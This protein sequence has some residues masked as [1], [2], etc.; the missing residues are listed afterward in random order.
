MFKMS[1]SCGD[2]CHSVGITPVDTLLIPYRASGLD[3]GCNAGLPCYFDTV[4]EGEGIRSHYRTVEVES[5]APALAMACLSASLGGLSDTAGQKHGIFGEYYGVGLECLTS[6]LAKADP[7]LRSRGDN[8][9]G[10]FFRLSTFQL[11][12]WTRIPPSSER[13]FWPKALLRCQAG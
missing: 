8:G 12:S 6:L 4:R 10:L 2:H 13:N 5:K 9:H 11:L 7:L 3:Y 1:E